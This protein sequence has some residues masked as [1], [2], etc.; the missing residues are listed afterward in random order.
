MM[1]VVMT[2]KLKRSQV[3][4][5]LQSQRQ[6]VVMTAIRSNQDI[7]YFEDPELPMIW[8]NE[9]SGKESLRLNK[10]GLYELKAMF[11]MYPV[12]LKPGFQVKNV[13]IKY[14]EEELTYPYYLDNKKLVLF[15]AKDVL[16]FKLHDGDLDSWART[17][18]VNDK[19]Q[20]P[21]TLPENS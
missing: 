6:K 9:Y 14:L 21:P 10:S 5:L 18:W 2:K 8:H 12:P 20:E 7:P 17:R 11:K 1:K 3:N 4:K 19:Y 15:N 16:D 13:H